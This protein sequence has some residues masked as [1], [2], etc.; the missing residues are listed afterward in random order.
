MNNTTL[1]W[2]AV[3]VGLA[4]LALAG[5]YWFVPAGSLPTF[6]PGFVEGSTHVHVKHG[7]IFLILALVLLGFAYTKRP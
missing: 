2:G 3:V 4:C 5:M 7:V 1:F 6:A